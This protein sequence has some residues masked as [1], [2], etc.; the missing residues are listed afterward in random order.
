MKRILLILLGSL[1]L[2]LGIIGVFIPVFPQT[3]FFIL[4]AF[5]YVRSS[6]HLY[7]WLI[8]HKIFGKHLNNYLTHRAIS[9]SAKRWMFFI[10]WVSTILSFIFVNVLW[11]RIILVVACIAMSVVI[12]TVKSLDENQPRKNQNN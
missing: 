10:L 7:N 12:C 3:P 2:S 11:V 4:C 5:C 1:S 9:K 8:E 6:K